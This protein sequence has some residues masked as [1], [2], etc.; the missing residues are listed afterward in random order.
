MIRFYDFQCTNIPVI[1][2][3]QLQSLFKEKKKKNI[4]IFSHLISLEL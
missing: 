4:T 3:L 2:Y 1:G